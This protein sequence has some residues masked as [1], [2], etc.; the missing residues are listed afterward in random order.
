MKSA[1]SPAK[2]RVCFVHVPRAEGLPRIKLLPI[3]LLALADHLSR[4]GFDSR[5]THLGL[6][7][8]LNHRFSLP[9]RLRARGA[10]AALFDLHWHYQTSAVM[11]EAA[12][13]KKLLPALPVI[14]GGHTASYFASEILAGFPE[15]DF[16]V[17]GDAEEPL[18]RLLRALRTGGR[19][20]GIPNLTWRRGGRVVRNPQSY[21]VD[22]KTVDAEDFAAFR[23]LE[24]GGEYI[25]RLS[26]GLGEHDTEPV[27]YFAP[28]RG[29]SVSCSFCGGSR[30]AQKLVFGRERVLFMSRAAAVR[31]ILAAQR[32]GFRKVNICS[33]PLPDG[34]YYPRLFAALAGS[35][36]RMKMDFECYALP[37]RRFIDAFARSF[38]P[39]SSVTI[40]PETG[41][42]R[43]RR[44]NKGMRFSNEALLEALRLLRDRDIKVYLAF[45]AGLPFED[46]K[47]AVETLELINLVR[48][49]FPGVESNAEP[50]ALEPASLWFL[51]R[52]KYG[53]RSEKRAFKDYFDAEGEDFPVFH[54]TAAF[55]AADIRAL[56]ELYRAEAGCAYKT[57]F[58]LKLLRGSGE[59]LKKV[60]L[61]AARLAC[62]DCR[63]FARCFGLDR[64]AS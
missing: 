19:L 62:R 43:V 31:N 20:D 57:S 49:R 8:A 13:I 29:C 58:F 54:R 45:T 1:K 23:L 30:A 44:K 41:S 7:K 2:R 5:V 48:N 10:A 9:A 60:S 15:V 28:A 4:A 56:L 25:R 46:R 64:L 38:G 59:D 22:R 52:E 53:V 6:E 32:L 42:E 50:I 63:D 27:F 11:A 17:R 35:G 51:F 55:S 34:D 21:V 37:N 12:G 33:D 61:P 39:G 40:S 16:V 24:H 26:T 18:P 3:G 36:F 14:L 47:A